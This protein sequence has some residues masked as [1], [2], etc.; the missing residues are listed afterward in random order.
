MISYIAYTFNRFKSDIIVSIL[1]T[2]S[3]ILNNIVNKYIK[4]I[5]GVQ[6]IEIT[7]ITNTYR[8]ATLDEWR[9][10]AGTKYIPE[11]GLIVEED[12][13]VEEEMISGC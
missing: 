5:D 11:K 13:S 9:N 7:R 8:M 3:S 1:C 2:G 12:S 4:S 10:F 6:D